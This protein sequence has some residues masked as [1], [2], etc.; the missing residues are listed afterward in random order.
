[1]RAYVA[2]RRWRGRLDAIPLRRHAQIVLQL[3]RYIR[4]HETFL[5]PHWL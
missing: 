1:V 2:G 5:F 3:G 4:P